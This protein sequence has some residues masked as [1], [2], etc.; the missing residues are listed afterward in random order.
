MGFSS[1]PRFASLPPATGVGLRP[2]SP[3][4]RVVRFAASQNL[5]IAE[6]IPFDTI[7]IIEH[8][9]TILR[10]VTALPSFAA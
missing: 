1:Y 10:K 6:A 3:A 2:G 9:I 5:L 4:I 7:G 8:N